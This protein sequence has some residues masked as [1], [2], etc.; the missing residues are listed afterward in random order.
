MISGNGRFVVFH[1]KADNFVTADSNAADDVFIRD[2]DLGIT[3]L[4]SINSS[5]TDSGSGATFKGASFYPTVSDDGRFVTFVSFATDLVAGGKVEKVP[6][7]YVR[8]R[9]TD[10][11][12]VFDEPGGAL[13]RL[14]SVTRDGEGAGLSGADLLGTGS[15]WRPIISPNGVYVAFASGATDLAITQKAP[16]GAEVVDGNGFAADVI[17]AAVDGS[18]LEYMNLNQ[19]GTASSTFVF[20]PRSSNPSLSANGGTVAYESNGYNLVDTVPANV[21]D[22][23]TNVFVG[24]GGASSLVSINA[25][26]DNGGDFASKVPAISGDGR[27]VAF[28]SRATD[29]IADA[30]DT[31]G[32]GD[33]FVRDLVAGRT[34]LVSQAAGT[35]G[36]GG[37]GASPPSFAERKNFAG[38]PSIS[39]N[40]RFIAFSSR[41]SN[42]LDPS[43]P[44]TD[45][46][47]I[48]DIYVFDRDADEDGIYDEPGA[49]E[50]LLASVNDETST[51]GT[52]GFFGSS[53]PTLS[54][55]GRFV[56]FATDQ[57]V[58]PGVTGMHVY[59]RD[60][61]D[62]VT[63]L[64]SPGG[65][66]SGGPIAAGSSGDFNITLSDF[67]NQIDR[68]AYVSLSSTLDPDVSDTN[69]G[70]DVYAYTPPTD[71][72]LT[73]NFATGT[74]T[75]SQG[76]RVR[77]EDA[78][79]FEVGYYRS[80]DRQFDAADELLGTVTVS[81]PELLMVNSN[82]FL[83]A[84]IGS[85]EGSITLPGVAGADTLD[86]YFLLVVG[87]H[88]DE[89]TEFDGDPFHEDNVVAARGLYHLPGGP[90]FV[91]GSRLGDEMSVTIKESTLTFDY[92]TT[93]FGIPATF[94]YPLADVSEVR[95]RTHEGSDTVVGGDLPDV[96]F[97]GDDDDKISGAGGDDTLD[98]G[99]G[100][101]TILGG[102]GDDVIFDGP[103]DDF[104]DGGTGDD[105]II[106][107]PGSDDIFID[108]GGIDTLD[109]SLADQAI[110]LDLDLD[111]LQ[112][113]DAPGNTID[114]DGIFEDVV[115]SRFDD[116]FT[117]R[118]I[119]GG[120]LVLG[121]EGND[122]LTIDVG[123]QTFIDDGSRVTFPGNSF[124]DIVYSEFEEVRIVD[125]VFMGDIDRDGNVDFSDF[126]TLSTNYGRDSVAR[127]E[128]G[129]ID[130]DGTVGFRDFLLLSRNFDRS[131]PE[132]VVRTEAAATDAFFA[133]ASDDDTDDDGNEIGLEL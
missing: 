23:G 77:H 94:T 14:L 1:S 133:T 79:P 83:D 113:V 119:A 99:P 32:F 105:T 43:G 81:D 98:G 20:S 62:K 118:P 15:D 73:R 66:G 103:G 63:Y 8:D 91:H 39:E 85:E 108:G 57:T 116:V 88:L 68:V 46:N 69:G 100:D 49:T 70:V 65:P 56:A 132:E 89:V 38:G 110:E 78:S 29:L 31:N 33:V 60:L 58:L 104:I 28:I 130:G 53:N 111:D 21:L 114:L 3:S 107:T 74:T 36:I 125:L 59:V 93:G 129:D 47:L 128:D 45:T 18:T 48:P 12:G 4:V 34:T 106:S 120:R 52:A 72:Q 24:G 76:I 86:D 50:M 9:D 96:I 124:G 51:S 17:R 64:A 25:A 102:P 123:G 40:G 41:A 42:L 90:L 27:H 22:W 82:F 101:D 71:V 2:L 26:G 112:I 84:P 115:G 16:D 67:T 44:V 35:P 7:V 10:G 97:A 121:G 54:A 126:I 87:D 6:N 127:R 92:G 109:F 80:T 117:V 131:L 122:S 55:N 5:G 61:E 37:N 19:A 95:V 11:N 30:S 13:T 75:H